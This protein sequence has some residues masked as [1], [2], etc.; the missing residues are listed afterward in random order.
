VHTLL[1]TTYSF[2]VPWVFCTSF[3]LSIVLFHFEENNKHGLSNSSKLI[4]MPYCQEKRNQI[5]WCRIPDTSKILSNK[6]PF[7]RLQ[8]LCKGDL[9]V[10][11]RLSQQFTITSTRQF[12]PSTLDKLELQNS[13]FEVDRSSIK[14]YDFEFRRDCNQQKMA[15][16]PK[17]RTPKL[18]DGLTVSPKMKTT[19]GD[20]VGTRSLI[21]STLGVE[22]RVGAMG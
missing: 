1:V 11:W 22:G 2:I 20:R 21:R 17:W 15:K 18:F 9:Y 14:I 5:H 19:E 3:L 7:A 6:E 16:K 13:T 8:N 10:W 12:V 4:L